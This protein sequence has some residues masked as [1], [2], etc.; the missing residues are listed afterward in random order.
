MSVDIHD[1]ITCATFCDDRLRGL[2]VAMGRISS[3]PID[4]LRRPYNTLALPCECVIHKKL[5]YRKLQWAMGPPGSPRTGEN[6][7]IGKH[8]SQTIISRLLVSNNA[9]R[10]RIFRRLVWPCPLDF[11]SEIEDVTQYRPLG[12]ASKASALCLARAGPRAD[13]GKNMWNV[14][15]RIKTVFSGNSFLAVSQ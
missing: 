8:N 13:A 12:E 14:L 6:P 7:S 10:I 15:F 2:G 4:L 5:R 3:F 11:L 1:V 9:S